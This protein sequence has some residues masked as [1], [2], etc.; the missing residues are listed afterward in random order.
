MSTE[1]KLL[2]IN[3]YYHDELEK[4]L[5]IIHQLQELDVKYNIHLPESI[6]QEV[7]EFEE[8]F[9]FKYHDR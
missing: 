3:E 8:N 1:G 4:A 7:D 2:E 5:S 6:K 9:R